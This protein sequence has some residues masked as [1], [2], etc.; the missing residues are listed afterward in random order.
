MPL[1]GLYDTLGPVVKTSSDLNIIAIQGKHGLQG[2]DGLTHLAKLEKPAAT[3]LRRLYPVPHP[4]GVKS[5]PRK[6]FSPVPVPVQSA[7]AGRNRDT[8]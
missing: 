5:S 8:I 3:D 6:I 2:L 7:T 1:K 4:L